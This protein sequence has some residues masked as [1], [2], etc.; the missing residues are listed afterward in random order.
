MVRGKRNEQRGRKASDN[1]NRGLRIGAED[2]DA[3]GDR[4]RIILDCTSTKRDRT[5]LRSFLSSSESARKFS[6]YL[7]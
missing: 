1:T 4:N 6:S 2:Q 7:T 5:S 3:S